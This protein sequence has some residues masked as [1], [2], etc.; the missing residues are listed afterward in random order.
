ML[1]LFRLSLRSSVFS[2]HSPL[3]GNLFYPPIS[4]IFCSLMIPTVTS[5]LGCHKA[6]PTQMSKMFHALLPSVIPLPSVQKA[7]TFPSVAN[8]HKWYP[9]SAGERARCLGV[10]LDLLLVQWLNLLPFSQYVLHTMANTAL[11]NISQFMKVSKKSFN[12]FQFHT[13]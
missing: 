11:K 3:L 6:S 2:V 9:C 1:V 7:R 12:N 10:I 4:I 5:L 8:L 13:E